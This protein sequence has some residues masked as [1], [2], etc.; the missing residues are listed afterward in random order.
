MLEKMI[1]IA[2]GLSTALVV[3]I[4]SL[5]TVHAGSEFDAFAGHYVVISIRQ[6]SFVAAPLD[7]T[8]GKPNT[9][10]GKS[11]HFNTDGLVLEGIGCDAWQAQK[12]TT[13]VDFATDRNLADLH[14]P[15]MKRAN[16]AGDK[17]IMNLY[18][19]SCEGEAFTNLYQV[20]KRVLVMSW[21]N[22]KQYLILERPLS[23]TQVK[24]LQTALKSL[25]FYAGTLSGQ[26]D[27]ATI[28]AVRAYY[29]DLLSTSMIAIP[30]RPAITENL[31]DRL[32]V[33]K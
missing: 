22:S 11:V 27:T 21:A 13:T 24:K 23:S 8:P 33:L 18:K 16:L 5:A 7:L 10:I 4:M 2:A 3:L 25:Q 14:L 28:E 31:L 15:Y 20:D 9:V 1:D 19:I 17:R 29:F 26:L 30:K 6:N 12:T 32:N